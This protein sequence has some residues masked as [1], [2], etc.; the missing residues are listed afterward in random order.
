MVTRPLMLDEHNQAI[1]QK[2][3]EMDED[4]KDEC[5]TFVYKN[6]KPQADV[7]CYDDVVMWDAICLQMLKEK[8]KHKKKL[9]QEER[10][11]ISL[12][13]RKRTDVWWTKFGARRGTVSR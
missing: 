4:L 13:T 9:E 7:N 3:L 5:F 8:S 11:Q 12:L 1:K 2:L 6:W 10:P